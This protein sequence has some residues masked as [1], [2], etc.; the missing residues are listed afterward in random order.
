MAAGALEPSD[1]LAPPLTNGRP[2]GPKGGSKETSPEEKKVLEEESKKESDEESS[3]DD[4]EGKKERNTPGISVAEIS[5]IKTEETPALLGGEG[6]GEEGSPAGTA[7]ENGKEKEGADPMDVVEDDG[8]GEL[9]VGKFD[10]VVSKGKRK[11]RAAPADVQPER[12]APPTAPQDGGE[13]V[14]IEV[15]ENEGGKEGM[16]VEDMLESGEDSSS[17]SDGPE[18]P[19][20]K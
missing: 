2:Q 16:V 1:L 15:A 17:E 9:G 7:L 14:C 10:G 8:H 4:E 3:D 6:M 11:A 12:V 19:R 18:P 13:G 5:S 20:R